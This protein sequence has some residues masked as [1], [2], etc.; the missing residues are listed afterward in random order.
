MKYIVIK[1]SEDH[2]SRLK[3]GDTIHFNLAYFLETD[4]VNIMGAHYDLKSFSEH[5]KKKIRKNK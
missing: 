1:E 2:A 5:F 4:I 3:I